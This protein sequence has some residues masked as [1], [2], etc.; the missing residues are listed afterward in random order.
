MIGS[1]L[2]LGALVALA[3]YVDRRRARIAKYGGDWDGRNANGVRFKIHPNGDASYSVEDTVR[4]MRASGELDR[5]GRFFAE[6]K[7]KALPL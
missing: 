6:F 5:F 7:G 3:I 2:I 1:V 4:R